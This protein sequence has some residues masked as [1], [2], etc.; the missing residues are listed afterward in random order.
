MRK[1]LSFLVG[2]PV[3]AGTP[4]LSYLVLVRARLARY[5]SCKGGTTSALRQNSGSMFV[6]ER[7]PQNIKERYRFEFE[8]IPFS[9]P[10][11]RPDNLVDS[12][13]SDSLA[14]ALAI[15]YYASNPDDQKS[16]KH[17]VLFSAAFQYQ[18]KN[19]GL[20]NAR[21]EQIS[22]EDSI[23]SSAYSLY[24]KWMACCKNNALALVLA[25]RDADLLE[26][27]FG[28]H[29]L[30]IQKNIFY[31]LIK[32]KKENQTTVVSCHP[33]ELPL[34]AEAM[35]LKWPFLQKGLSLKKI[36][37]ILAFFVAMALT[38]A[39]SFSLRIWDKQ[40]DFAF[41]QELSIH[42]I[43]H[44][45]D[46]VE[47]GGGAVQGVSHGSI[48]LLISKQHPQK[49]ALV[50]V[51]DV[52]SLQSIAY[53]ITKKEWDS[54]S[55]KRIDLPFTWLSSLSLVDEES[56]KAREL[57]RNPK[58]KAF[59]I[60]IAQENQAKIPLYIQN[61]L[62]NLEQEQ[63]IQISQDISAS[64]AVISYR[65]KAIM[66]YPTESYLS[67]KKEIP[68]L[69]I[70]LE[71]D[72]ASAKKLRDTL[73]EWKRVHLILDWQAPETSLSVS[74][75]L[76]KMKAIAESTEMPHL[77]HAEIFGIEVE[78]HSKE[79]IYPLILHINSLWH[80]QCLYP[81]NEPQAIEAGKS[82]IVIKLKVDSQ[83]IWGKE[84]AK[85]LITTF[86]IS[87]KELRLDAKGQYREGGKK[88]GRIPFFLSSIAKK[89]DKLQ[90]DRDILR[91]EDP[92]DWTFVTM[93]WF[94]LPPGNRK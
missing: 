55:P 44:A 13:Y 59:K 50:M 68:F 27:Q 5:H 78:N 41:W 58:Q 85:I 25:K 93:F 16:I 53:L 82:K 88:Y 49:A 94:T 29:P 86:P 62:Q 7:L 84:T 65:E 48:F 20:D 8:T 51:E 92:L 56:W 11:A 30:S 3:D 73:L 9:P 61:T 46:K 12:G 71:E 74:V 28:I 6:W 31:D 22:Q 81:I 63:W 47:L 33:E 57:F 69:S 26:R 70:D 45:L 89:C 4:E 18:E 23:E 37:G 17:L 64:H 90:M 21:L 80:L 15:S 67:H 35:D 75:R 19:Q 24:N 43:Y 2:F 39:L 77:D 36:Q 14:S 76:K 1:K 38:L 40:E 10:N 83:K 87:P 72:Q 52:S 54:I 34:L 60:Y 32:Q 91:M 42:K 79:K 66:L